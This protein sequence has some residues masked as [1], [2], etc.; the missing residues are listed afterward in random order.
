MKEE[1][2]TEEIALDV[3]TP[4]A[5]DHNRQVGFQS[6]PS[7]HHA[8]NIYPTSWA[9]NLGS[10]A[11]QVAHSLEDLWPR[12]SGQ[13]SRN[14]SRGLGRSGRHPRSPSGESLNLLFLDFHSLFSETKRVKFSSFKWLVLGSF[15]K[16]VKS[17][18]LFPENAHKVLVD[19]VTDIW[20]MHLSACSCLRTLILAVLLAWSIFLVF[21]SSLILIAPPRALPWVPCPG[22]TSHGPSWPCCG[23]RPLFSSS[24]LSPTSL[25]ALVTVTP[26]THRMWAPRGQGACGSLLPCFQWCGQLQLLRCLINSC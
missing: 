1:I 8:R 13:T 5:L 23:H 6:H 16:Y 15:L 7:S 4:V 14:I 20:R 19:L 24:L 10:L 26:Q 9:K 2:L 12:S 11:F 25:S 22:I 17:C 3:L 18:G 21:L